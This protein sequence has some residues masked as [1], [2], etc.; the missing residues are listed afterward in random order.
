M[1]TLLTRAAAQAGVMPVVPGVPAGVEASI[2]AGAEG[3]WL[4]LLNHNDSTVTVPVPRGA[5]DVLTG[6]GLA[7]RVAIERRGVVIA[8]L[9]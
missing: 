7:E 3:R 8:Q 2:R 1:D 6:Q 5:T 4:F 9:A